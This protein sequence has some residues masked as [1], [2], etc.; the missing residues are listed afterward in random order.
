MRTPDSGNAVIP[1]QRKVGVV[2]DVLHRKIEMQKSPDQQHKGHHHK[3]ALAECSRTCDG[4]HRAVVFPC[5]HDGQDALRERQQQRE[6]QRDLA[7]LRRHGEPPASLPSG[8]G[9]SLCAF[10]MASFSSFGI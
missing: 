9:L 4:H 1:G 8:I 2:R 7:Q 5:A 3:K 6:D 10:A